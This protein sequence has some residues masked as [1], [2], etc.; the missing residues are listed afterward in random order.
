MSLEVAKVLD[1][2]LEPLHTV[3][4]KALQ[5]AAFAF[6][7]DW[8]ADFFV[9]GASAYRPEPDLDAVLVEHRGW[10]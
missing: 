4:Y 9:L 5:I 10:L 8:Y 1:N 7:L 2:D 6:A 3:R